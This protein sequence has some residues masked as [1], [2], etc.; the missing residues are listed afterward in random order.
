MNVVLNKEKMEG[1]NLLSLSCYKECG[2]KINIEVVYKNE[3][4]VAETN[5][6]ITLNEFD[7][8]IE[9][10]LKNIEIPFHINTSSELDFFGL[11]IFIEENKINNQKL[12]C[13]NLEGLNGIK[14]SL[15]D[16]KIDSKIEKIFSHSIL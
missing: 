11:E 16:I 12:I 1:D 4:L 5:E 7:L 3:N 2:N 6:E 10:L 15:K 8:I 13:T 9:K 14:N